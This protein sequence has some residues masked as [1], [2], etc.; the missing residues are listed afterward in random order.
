LFIGEVFGDGPN[1]NQE[2]IGDGDGVAKGLM[3]REAMAVRT[4]TAS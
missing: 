4:G 1:R 2:G 3:A